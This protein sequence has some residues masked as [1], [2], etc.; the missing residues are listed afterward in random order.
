MTEG[1]LERWLEGFNETED[2]I[3]IQ[4]TWHILQETG[5]VSFFGSG[6]SYI[7]NQKPVWDRNNVYDEYEVTYHKSSPSPPFYPPRTGLEWLK[8]Y[9][10]TGLMFHEEPGI[11]AYSLGFKW[12]RKEKLLLTL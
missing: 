8:T 7:I 12:A 5:N 6:G 2:V 10:E 1:Q 11:T 9:K 4:S 3:D